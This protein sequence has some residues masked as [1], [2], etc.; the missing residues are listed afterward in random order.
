LV[1]CRRSR[2]LLLLFGVREPSDAERSTFETWD[3][4][5]N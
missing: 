4:L 1:D 5:S 3:G 2:F